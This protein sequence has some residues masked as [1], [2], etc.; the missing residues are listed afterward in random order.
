MT[1]LV[2]VYHNAVLAGGL[3]IKLSNQEMIWMIQ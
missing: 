2:T 3:R 1:E